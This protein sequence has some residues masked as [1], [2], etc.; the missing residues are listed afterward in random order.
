M[1][2]T[3]TVSAI[4]L[5]TILSSCDDMLCGQLSGEKLS[6]YDSAAR[7]YDG[8]VII[9]RIPCEFNYINIYL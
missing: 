6:M 7:I 1:K 9:E 5:F 2:V 8:E 4:M 3:V